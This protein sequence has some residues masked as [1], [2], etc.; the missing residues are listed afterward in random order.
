[1]GCLREFAD[2][3]INLTRIESRPR[4]ERLGSY[5]FFADLL[6]HAEREPV[7]S[8]L[9]GLGAECAEVRVLGSYRSARVAT[10]RH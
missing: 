8:A 6:G 4:R 1:V 7:R 5:M 10:L 2:R 3:D 9:V